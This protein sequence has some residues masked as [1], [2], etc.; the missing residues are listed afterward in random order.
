MKSA[1]EGPCNDLAEPLDRTNQRRILGQGKMRPDLV[2]QP[3]SRTPTG[4]SS[5]RF[6]IAGILGLAFEWRSTRLS[7][8]QTV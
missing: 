7:V 3:D 4:R 6:S 5:V 8:V 1:E 2:I